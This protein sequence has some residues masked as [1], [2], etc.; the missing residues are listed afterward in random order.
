[1]SPGA[2]GVP[3]EVALLGL[4]FWQRCCPCRDQGS[5]QGQRARQLGEL[6]DV[7]NDSLEHSCYSLDLIGEPLESLEGHRRAP[8]VE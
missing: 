1:V 8:R 3:Q 2:E 4:T 7:K 6:Q 5:R